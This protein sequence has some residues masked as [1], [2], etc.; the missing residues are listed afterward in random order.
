MQQLDA[1]NL[2]CPLP[3]LRANQALKKMAIGGQLEVLA[4]EPG[5]AQH[6][7]TYCDRNGYRLVTHS[8]SSDEHCIVIEKR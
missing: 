4:T 3:V 5:I 2:K 7:E 6:F 8:Q 1:R